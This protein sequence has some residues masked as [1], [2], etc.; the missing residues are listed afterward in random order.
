MRVSSKSLVFSALL[1]IFCHI[2]QKAGSVFHAAGLVSA[3]G[4]SP[5]KEVM[6][7]VLFVYNSKYYSCILLE[8][9]R[10]I[11]R[12]MFSAICS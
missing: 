9:K 5:L 1:L 10:I 12:R 6:N 3:P 11:P 4:T 2:N 8:E 7:R